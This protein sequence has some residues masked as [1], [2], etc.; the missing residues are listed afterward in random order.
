MNRK[1]A[2]FWL[3]TVL[4]VIVSLV[5]SSVAGFRVSY[6]K[7]ASIA[8]IHKA[9]KAGELTARELVQMYL[10]RIEAYDKKGPFLNSIIGINPR[11]LQ[12]AAELDK[13]F[14]ESGFVGPLHGIPVIVKDNFDTYDMPTTNGILALKDSVPPDDAYM[15][16]KLREAGAIILA[17]ANMAEFADA[18]THTV[19]SVLPGYTRNP[20]DTRYSTAGSS[21]GTAAA[22]AANFATV[23][24]GTDTGASIRGPSSHQSIVGIRSTMGLSSRNGIVPLNTTQDVGGP[25]ARTLADAVAVFEVIVGYD[26]ADPVTEASKGKVP[27]NY[28]QFLD[29]D[30]LQGARIG[31]A[32]QLFEPEETD[33]EVLKLMNQ[34]IADLRTAGT[35]LVDPVRI[36]GLKEIHD[37]F[38]D[39][40]RLKHDFNRYLAS[41]GPDAPYKTLEEI[42]ESEK[43]HPHLK[44]R[45]KDAQ[46]EEPPDKNPK[47]QHDL[48][49]AQKLREAVLKAFDESNVDVLVYPTYKNAPRLIGDLNTPYGSNSSVVAPKIGF[50][51]INVPMGFT[52]G[53]LPAGLQFLGRPFSEPTLIKLGY[54]YEQATRHWRPPPT[55]PPLH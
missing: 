45:L 28:S 4:L 16:R 18:G 37:S 35:T 17:K 5:S 23:G 33:P 49:V 25:M 20:Y 29:R 1:T 31:V 22:I 38:K 39:S 41:L 24:L 7:E 54:S 10:D 13:K 30:G 34:A 14:V 36:E 47:N 3:S 12:V 55:S 48:R 27:E 6:V 2:S 46:A 42:I 26:M 21:G 53:N 50:P 44:K 51:A 52:H 8:D 32:R 15:I 43:Y 11:A 40:T 19:S 9:M